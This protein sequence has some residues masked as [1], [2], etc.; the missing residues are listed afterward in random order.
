MRVISLSVIFISVITVFAF[1]NAFPTD[2]NHVR[3][4]TLSD[5]YEIIPD[6]VC[7][8]IRFYSETR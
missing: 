5:V 3:Q 1:V 7:I 2:N 4:N 6:K 8:F